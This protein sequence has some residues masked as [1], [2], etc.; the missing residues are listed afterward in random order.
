[1]QFWIIAGE[2]FDT[3]QA[4][5]TFPLII[6]GGSFAAIIAGS[7]IKPFVNLYGSKN[8]VLLTLIFLLLSA[9]IGQYIKPTPKHA[10]VEKWYKPEEFNELRDIGLKLGFKGVVAGPLV[11]SSYKADEQ[12]YQ[13]KGLI[14][15]N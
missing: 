3:R 1:M 11:R 10:T 12:Y 8:L 5:K 6:A 14:P 4:K 7:S 13:A 15:I 2:V 9:F